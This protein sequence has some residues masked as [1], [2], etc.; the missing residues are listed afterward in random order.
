MRSCAPPGCGTV[1]P[2]AEAVRDGG[3]PPEFDLHGHVGIRLLDA[4]DDD[5]RRVERQ[6]GPLHGRLAREPDITIRFVDRLELRGS[7]TYVGL[8]DAGF[9]EHA[10][11]LLRGKGNVQG[12]AR[13]AFQDVG[14]S[15]HI[16]CERSLPDVPLLLAIINMTALAKGVLPLHGSAFVHEGRGVLATGWAKGG[17]TEMLLS[18]ADRGADYV[19]DEWVYLTPDG[20][21]FGLPEPIRLWRWQLAQLPRFADRLRRSERLR[22]LALDVA[23][24]GL[25]G[26]A[27]RARPAGTA[28]VLRRAAPVVRRQVNVQVP[29]ARL[30]GARA[31]ALRSQLERIIFVSS[32]Q[33][34]EVRVEAIDASDVA[35]RMLAS[36]AEERQAFMSYYR[37]FRF[38][39]PQLRSPLVERASQV[40]TRLMAKCLRGS[41]AV[42]LR[43]PYPM[44]IAA[45]SE[46]VMDF[47][48][49][50]PASR[51][52]PARCSCRP[53]GP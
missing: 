12:K 30:F 32:H 39:F 34:R 16:E 46:P 11:Y 14:A 36:N 45:L 26:I 35:S 3:G 52:R 7:L 48:V 38:A 23:A 31:I 1:V 22:L 29:P 18:F 2:V 19:G 47:I 25:E 50:E 40:E 44:D 49:N 8:H 6:L 21:M 4:R 20:G 24:R 27:P 28:S 51:R 5:V 9:D 41:P 42:W 33:A 53:S 13:L 37:Q 17:K 43:H 15:C 10:F